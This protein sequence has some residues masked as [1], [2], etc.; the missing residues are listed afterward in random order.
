[1]GTPDYISPEVLTESCYDFS[2][3]I[4]GIGVVMFEC[5][6]GYPPF[7]HD[8]SKEVCNRVVNWLQY[9]EFPEDVKV[10]TEAKM[11]ILGMMNNKEQ[12]L[13]VKQIKIHPFFRNFDWKTV[14]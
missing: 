4:W 8:D 2:V 7:S 6:F 9:L 13:T 11:L 12:R 1:M 5:L 10:S 14:R 3:D